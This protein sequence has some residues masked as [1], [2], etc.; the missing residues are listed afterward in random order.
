MDRVTV[1]LRTSLFSFGG[2]D[3]HVPAGVMVVVGQIVDRPASGL[4]LETHEFL[5]E[6][7]RRLS[8]ESITIQLPWAKIDHVIV[9]AD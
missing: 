4:V 7:G 3:A 9:H 1:F 5:D 2:A 8:E 6:R